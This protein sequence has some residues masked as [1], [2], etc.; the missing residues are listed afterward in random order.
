MDNNLTQAQFQQLMTGFMEYLSR[1]ANASVLQNP[2]QSNLMFQTYMQNHQGVMRS[3]PLGPRTSANKIYDSGP[4]TWYA[5]DIISDVSFAGSELIQWIPTSSRP[6]ENKKK[7]VSHLGWIA[8]EGWGETTALTDYSAWLEEHLVADCEYGPSTKWDAYQY[9]MGY[10]D[11][12]F[13]SDRFDIIPDF[14]ITQEYDRSPVYAIRGPNAGMRLDSEAEFGIART[15]QMMQQH[16]NWNIHS[17]VAGGNMQWDGISSILTASYVSNHASSGSSTTGLTDWANPLIVDGSTLTAPEDILQVLMEMVRRIRRRLIPRGMAPAP[18]DMAIYMDESMWSRLVDAMVVLGL[19]PAN[20]NYV[21]GGQTPGN[22]IQD[23]NMFMS[24][25]LGYGYLPV[26]G[27]NVPIMPANGIGFTNPTTTTVSGDIFILTRRG[28]GMTFL[29]QQYF[30]W[31]T[32]RI[33]EG[34]DVDWDVSASGLFKYGWFKDG[35][36]CYRYYLGTGGRL[37]SYFQPAQ[38]RLMN[39]TMSVTPLENI[40]GLFPNENFYA[41][42][43][44]TGTI[45]AGHGA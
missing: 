22:V 18:G 5:D 30:D 17:G 29:E 20:P 45:G 31:S 24:G 33:P 8:P 16:L 7:T 1:N 35:Q 10:G 2:V 4:W 19:V 37:V 36:K 25:G 3:S 12:S 14:M 23:R 44:T 42:D 41:L 28:G 11:A 27:F 21:T 38:G 40:E 13:S 15:V 26:D 6:L 34:L 32:A 43:S 39:V 9:E